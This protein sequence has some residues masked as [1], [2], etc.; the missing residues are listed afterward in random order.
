MA[1]ITL[2]PGVVFGS[3]SPTSPS[4]SGPSSGAPLLAGDTH[5]LATMTGRTMLARS[6]AE[7]L[8]FKITRFSVGIA[9]YDPTTWDRALPV[10]N[11]RTTLQ[12]EIFADIVDLIET[13]ND[14]GRSFYCRLQPTEALNGLGEI[15]IWAEIVDSPENPAE[16][17]TTFLFALV[18]QPFEGHNEDYTYIYRI[19][20]QY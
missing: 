5:A 9:G 15:G 1:S 19:V 18:N 20:V 10:D 12:S 13:P 7:G 2:V 4:S 14:T 8:A 16:V 11:T 6:W 3:L 17:G